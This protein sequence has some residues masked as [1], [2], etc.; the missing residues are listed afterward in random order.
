[1]ARRLITRGDEVVV[2]VRPGSPANGCLDA[3]PV[4]A[5]RQRRGPACRP[6]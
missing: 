1:V 5:G 6:V 4:V 3:A 2:T